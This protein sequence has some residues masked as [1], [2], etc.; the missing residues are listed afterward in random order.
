MERED[1]VEGEAKIELISGCT[2]T[3]EEPEDED[4]VI[5]D[6][7][8]SATVMPTSRLTRNGGGTRLGPECSA[9]PSRSNSPASVAGVC[10]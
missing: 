9:P 8:C 2:L 6:G 10:R 3:D 4:R 1:E 7:L 5:A